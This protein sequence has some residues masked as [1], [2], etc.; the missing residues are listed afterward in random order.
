MNTSIVVIVITIVILNYIYYR[1]KIFRLKKKLSRFKDSFRIPYDHYSD[2]QRKEV[3]FYRF[4]AQEL[5]QCNKVDLPAVKRIF[6][7]Y[8]ELHNNK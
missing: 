5:K 4:L 7:T 8:K 2:L 6:D 1:I 3:V